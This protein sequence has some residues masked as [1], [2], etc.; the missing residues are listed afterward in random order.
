M[1]IAGSSICVSLTSLALK[2]KLLNYCCIGYW[3]TTRLHGQGARRRPSVVRHWF[4]QSNRSGFPTVTSRPAL[5]RDALAFWAWCTR[6]K[7]PPPR[8][9]QPG[10][11][12]KTTQHHRRS[13]QVRICARSRSPRRAPQCGL[14]PSFA[15]A[16]VCVAARSSCSTPLL[17]LAPLNTWAANLR[18]CAVYARDMRSPAKLRGPSKACGGVSRWGG[19]PG[20]VQLSAR[21]AE[22][23]K[24]ARSFVFFVCSSLTPNE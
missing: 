20:F 19:G 15:S 3:I 6:A 7:T 9:Q 18:S 10:G 13:P 8:F 4:D 14:R 21:G 5:S 1:I 11:I 23:M 24:T 16:P 12:P 2:C 17:C 22:K